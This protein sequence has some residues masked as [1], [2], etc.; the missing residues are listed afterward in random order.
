MIA[1]EKDDGDDDANVKMGKDGES[2]TSGHR[3]RAAKQH[4]T[5]SSG[6]P[7]PLMIPYRMTRSLFEYFKVHLQCKDE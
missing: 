7:L 1:S 5:S 4:H 2:S 6:T 3:R